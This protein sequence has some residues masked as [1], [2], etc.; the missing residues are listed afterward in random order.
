MTDWMMW[1]ALAGVLVVV[2]LFTGTFYILMIAIGATAGVVAALG[3]ASGA[4][5]IVIAA[6][7]G[8]LA[9][10]VLHKSRLGAPGRKNAERDPD[11]NIDIGQHLQVPLWHARVI[12]R[13]APWDVELHPGA[14]QEAGEFRIIEVSGNRLIVSNA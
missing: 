10:G 12:Y 9:T 11:V 4:M 6:V 1:L 14:R 13:G 7:A 5:Q 8:V 2:E 3:G